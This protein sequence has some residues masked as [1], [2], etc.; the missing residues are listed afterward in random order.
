MRKSRNLKTVIRTRLVGRGRTPKKAP[1]EK[2]LNCEHR[3]RYITAV[4]PPARVV[5]LLCRRGIRPSQ[6]TMF[7]ESVGSKRLPSFFDCMFATS[8]SV[9]FDNL[10]AAAFHQFECDRAGRNRS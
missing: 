8:R 1:Q 7:A 2:Q 4:S 10:T 5:A 3:R 6:G 9:P